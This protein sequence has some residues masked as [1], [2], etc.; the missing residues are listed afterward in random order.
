MKMEHQ[1]I[2]VLL[3]CHNRRD[4]TVECLK[5]LFECSIP[6]GYELDV[7]LV[8]DGSTDGTGKAVREKFP[9]VNVIQGDGSL[10][11]NGGMRLAWETAAQHKNYDFYLWLNDDTFLTEEALVELLVCYEKGTEETGSACLITG[12][13]RSVND[14]RF[15][16]GGRREDGPVIPNGKLEGCTYINGNAV[17]VPQEIFENLGNLSSDYT[18]AM[19]DYDY[20][21]RVMRRG[22]SNFTTRKY[23]AICEINNVLAWCNP[24][25]P[26]FKRLKLLY[27]ARGLN[28]PE[29]N[30]FRKKFWGW[31]W[32]IY[33]V[34]A[35]TKA[36]FPRI[37]RSLKMKIKF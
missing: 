34:K 36:I 6:K 13:C 17:L 18:H 24:E 1:S 10:Y 26:L 16:F 22:F 32:I 11:W 21:L 28:L 33:S 20:G 2:A 15:V 3:T 25:I 8:D 37:Y 7:F 23:I 27:S 29:Y 4:K 12:A 31:K 35:H 14:N 19:G 9:R 5:N 30:K